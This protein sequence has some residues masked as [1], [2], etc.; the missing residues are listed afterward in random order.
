[1]KLRPTLD[2]V[3]LTAVISLPWPAL[4]AFFGW[5]MDSYNE[6]EFV[7]SLSVSTRFTAVCLLMHEIVRH[8]SHRDGLAD[9]HFDWPEPCLQHLRRN[10]RWLVALG[11]P[12]VLWLVGLEVQASLPLASSTL[13]R[14]CFIVVMLLMAVVLHR[15]LLVRNSPFRQVVLYSEGGWLKPLQLAWRPVLVLLPASLAVLAAVGYYYT[16]QQAALRVLQTAAMILAV[17]TLGG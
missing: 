10:L 13:G 9:A 1:T 7:R 11:L 12:L 4:L 8:H 2:A 6:T 14:A 5:A 17:L 16:A 15:I 3:W